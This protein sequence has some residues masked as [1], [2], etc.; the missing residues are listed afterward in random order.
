MNKHPSGENLQDA[1][2]AP[3]N[4]QKRPAKARAE[5]TPADAKKSTARRTCIMVLGMHRS[6]TSALT[7]AISLLGAELPKNMLGANPTNPAG[8]WEPVR[9]M[10]LHD[11]MLGEAGS[12]WDDW[13]S[14][15]PNDLGAARLRFYK[16]EIAR[17]IDEEYGSAPL[18]VM[19]E[20]RISRFVPLY[21]E[22]LESMRVDVRYVLTER[23]PL[24]VIASL[25]KRGSFTYAFSALLWLRHELEAE[26]ATRGKPRVFLSYENMIDGWRSGVERMTETLQIE[27]PRPINDAQTALSTHFSAAHQHHVASRARLEADQR[28][29]KWVK[30][31][32]SALM[33]LE[34]NPNDATATAQLDAVR[35][36]FDC[37]S[38]VF[39]EAFFPEMRVRSVMDAEKRAQLQHLVA[40]QAPEIDRQTAEL[41]RLRRE[42]ENRDADIAKLRDSRLTEAEALNADWDRKERATK[43]REAELIAEA[44]R[45]TRLA[46]EAESQAQLLK[47]ELEALTA[48]QRRLILE[49]DQALSEKQRALEDLNVVHRSYM[50]RLTSLFRTK[51]KV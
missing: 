38:P 44:G 17:L 26:C 18:F 13:R 48:D 42:I 29:T 24:A 6:G 9:L 2:P 3:E 8:H 22:I 10:E 34:R 15:D 43:A 35:D 1:V 11:R 19:K 46:S 25:E 27:W 20:P 47:K 31:T 4:A 5:T 45:S 7:R 16:A 30:D 41:E 33:A 12:S 23:N 51:T 14:F 37:A 21:A 36:A 32:Y 50:W 28:M 39:G 40:I 49:R